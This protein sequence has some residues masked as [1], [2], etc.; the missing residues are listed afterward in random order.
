MNQPVQVSKSNH[1]FLLYPIPTLSSHVK[2]CE[3]Y[4]CCDEHQW[5]KVNDPYWLLLD[6]WNHCHAQYHDLHSILDIY[7]GFELWMYLDPVSTQHRFHQCPGYSRNPRFGR[8]NSHFTRFVLWIERDWCHSK[9][10]SDP[11][12]F[13]VGLFL[14]SEDCQPEQQSTH[15]NDHWW[16]HDLLLSISG[17]TLHTNDNSLRPIDVC[18]PRYGRYDHAIEWLIRT[19]INHWELD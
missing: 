12:V 11:S 2:Q 16:D 14:G 6:R 8:T 5:R 7:E 17:G 4:Q 3:F 19:P 15:H 9:S 18:F 1:H 10:P 13:I